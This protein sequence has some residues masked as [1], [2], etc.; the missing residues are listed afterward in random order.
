MQ[1]KSGQERNHDAP[2]VRRAE[3]L[4]E[5]AASMGV[6]YDT[7]WRASSDGRLKTLRFGK[8]LLVPAGEVE[9][10]LAEGL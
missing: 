1:T 10:V 2:V 6:S 7:A 3:T 5:F 4:R 9:R 8:R